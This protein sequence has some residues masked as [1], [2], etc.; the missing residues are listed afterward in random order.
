M[1]ATTDDT[2]PVIALYLVG[3]I[4]LIG[5]LVTMWVGNQWYAAK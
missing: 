5:F 2:R 1:M 4:W 3:M